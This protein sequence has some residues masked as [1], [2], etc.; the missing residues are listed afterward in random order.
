MRDSCS[1]EAEPPAAVRL[2]TSEKWRAARVLRRW[3]T[4]RAPVAEPARCDRPSDTGYIGPTT[5][6]NAPSPTTATAGDGRSTRAQTRTTTDVGV[7]S[8]SRCG[9]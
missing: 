4:A 1:V 7:V 8:S 2:R 3:T 6:R 5:A 9:C